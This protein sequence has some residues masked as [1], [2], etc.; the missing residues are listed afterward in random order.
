MSQHRR[1]LPVRYTI[2]L[3]KDG[4]VR[5]HIPDEKGQWIF[6]PDRVIDVPDVQQKT[7]EKWICHQCFSIIGGDVKDHICAHKFS[8]PD[9]NPGK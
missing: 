9:E 6:D 7:V 4:T 1:V 5:E 2:I 3:N 8:N